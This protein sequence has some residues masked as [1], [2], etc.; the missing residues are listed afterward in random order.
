[1]SLIDPK[2]LVAPFK[3]TIHMVTIVFLVVLFAVFRLATGGIDVQSGNIG[4][5]TSKLGTAPEAAQRPVLPD[6]VKT[7][8]P[9]TQDL[10]DIE[11]ALGLKS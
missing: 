8:E 10:Q 9:Q 2:H 6:A 5:G 3:N 4:T 11:K 7:S 1:M